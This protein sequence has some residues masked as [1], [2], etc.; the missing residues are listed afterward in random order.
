MNFIRKTCYINEG[1]F[2]W[3]I[4][5]CNAQLLIHPRF[6]YPIIAPNNYGSFLIPTLDDLREVRAECP[7][8]K[9]PAGK[10]RL[11]QLQVAFG[12]MMVC[13]QQV[14]LIRRKRTND[15]VRDIEKATSVLVSE[16]AILYGALLAGFDV[17]PT[18]GDE[19][20]HLNLRCDAR[21]H[22][23][24]QTLRNAWDKAQLVASVVKPASA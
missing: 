20:Y 9:E 24:L 21:Y 8:A 14:R 23:M 1:E 10:G 6:D 18:D 4:P 22:R 19:S 15:L 16:R 17:Q 13:Q 3:D 7:W 2:T 5:E 11:K 12:F